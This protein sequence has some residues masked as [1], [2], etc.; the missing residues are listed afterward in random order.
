[1]STPSHPSSFVPA[2]TPPTPPAS[3][4]ALLQQFQHLIG[5][6]PQ[7]LQAQA[8][9]LAPKLD[10]LFSNFPGPIG[11]K[12]D[13]AGDSGSL[14]DPVVFAGEPDMDEVEYTWEPQFKDDLEEYLY[15]VLSSLAGGWEIN[16]GSYG[17]ILLWANG[18]VELEIFRR[19]INEDG[20]ETHWRDAAEDEPKVRPEPLALYRAQHPSA[21]SSEAESTAASV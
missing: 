21:V 2:T 19:E 14:E 6:D 9:Q 20:G 8:S 16:E 11:A 18:E 17:R 13:G 1:M 12:F 10:V 4:S 3:V 15:G 5:N 7:S